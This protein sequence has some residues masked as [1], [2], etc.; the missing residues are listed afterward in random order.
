MPRDPEPPER[1]VVPAGGFDTLRD[2]AP[3]LRRPFTPEAVRW[4]VQ[5]VFGP[6]GKPNGCL[7]VGYIDARLVIERLNLLVPGL[8][9][10]T[11][12]PV[13]NGK[14]MWCHLTVGGV[15]RADVGESSK[16]FSKDL[17]SDAL[18][19][20]AVQFGVGVSIYAVP[21]ARLFLPKNAAHIETRG[22][23]EKTT[24]ALKDEGH[25][26]L[27]K[28]YAKWLGEHGVEAF[29]P[30]LD[31]GDSGEPVEPPPDVP[32][33][34]PVVDPE[35]VVELD[36]ARELY[37]RIC[38]LAPQGVAVGVLPAEFGERL[39]ALGSVADARKFNEWLAGKVVEA[40]RLGAGA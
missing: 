6:K 23:G 19:R 26:A 32:E 38:E 17:V 30:P 22:A 16:G 3:H 39:R 31:H 24:I 11:Y 37:A 21:Q 27:R 35:L 9:H 40:E 4:K 1:W 18:K 36:R 15:T 8:W 34:E 20:A 10:A 13:A 7:C 5:Q 25:A 33:P 12:D 2:A 28:R 14:L 29:G